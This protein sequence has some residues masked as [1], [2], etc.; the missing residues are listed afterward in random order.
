MLVFDDR[1]YG[2]TVHARDAEL[3][4]IDLEDIDE[5]IEVVLGNARSILLQPEEAEAK[6]HPR[7]SGQVIN[8]RSGNRTEQRAPR[9]K[10]AELE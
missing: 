6:L 5:E 2:I 1:S 4:G 9:P 8:S 10:L 3:S 7:E